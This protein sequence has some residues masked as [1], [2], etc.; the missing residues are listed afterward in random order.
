MSSE[1]VE[2][3]LRAVPCVLVTVCLNR[4][5]VAQ[6]DL[7]VAEDKATQAVRAKEELQHEKERLSRANGQLAG[8]LGVFRMKIGPRSLS[9]CLIETPD[10]VSE[11]GG[12]R[13]VFCL[14]N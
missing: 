4:L 10:R 9:K 13:D 2:R 1:K 8:E 5:V 6:A 3:V 11:G 7:Q 12:K 14:C